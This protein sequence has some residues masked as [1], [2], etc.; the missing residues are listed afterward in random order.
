MKYRDKALLITPTLLDN[1][2]WLENAPRSWHERAYQS[3]KGTL[4]RAPFKPTPEIQR[5][6]D[7]EKM[8]CG[9]L[10]RT[11]TPIE[12]LSSLA[13]ER[14]GN[15]KLP[16]GIEYTNIEAFYTHCKGGVFQT[17]LK[18]EIVVNDQSFLLY[19][20]ADVF[21]SNRIVDIKTTASFKPSKYTEKSQHEVYA[22]ASG[23]PQFVYVVAEFDEI[24]YKR[25]HVISID[26]DRNSALADIQGRI[27][28]LMF[29]LED[30][31]AL[32]RAYMTVFNRF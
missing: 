8:I 10:Q 25:T 18:K 2:R 7:F 26:I 1:F 11:E 31:P 14:Y 27:K 24:G 15:E 28:D 29:F 5:G 12:F 17:T 22:V 23:I 6:M 20:K 16:P 9:V 32:L 21:F 3:V 4:T 13:E 19:G 30:D